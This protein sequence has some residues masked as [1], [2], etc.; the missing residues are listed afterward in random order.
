M[1]HTLATFQKHLAG[2]DLKP[3]YLIAGEEHLLVLEAADALRAHARAL[4]YNERE[5]LDAETHF[6]WDALARAG[7]SMSLFASRRL[8]DMRLPTGKPG[9]EGSDAIVEYCENPPPDTVLMIVAN[10]WS[11]QQQAGAWVNAIERAGVVLP[12]WP[13]KA[14]EL[15][16]WIGQRMASR[17]LK[18]DRAAIAALADRVEGNSL[19]AAQE[20]D[21]L[22]LLHGSKP[23]DADTLEQ[24]V[25]DSARFDVFKLIDAALEGDTAR[26]IRV[27][28][29]LRAEGEQVPALM[30]WVLNQLQLIARL[31]SGPNLSSAF[32]NEHVWPA[33]ERVY[34]QALSRAD[35]KHWEKCLI[36][37]AR[38][39]RL[40]KGRGWGDP[41]R[42][43]ER[44]LAAVAMPR[45]KLLA[46]S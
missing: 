30:G 16:D 12:V 22:V 44:L 41:W 46:A 17:G 34:R 40:S 3:A 6:D 32:R 23:L 5:V 15:P 25:T 42:E 11:K 7:A 18:P 14:D 35:R 1:A 24:L 27:L 43:L 2:P 13:L 36:Q 20:I 8:I 33:R 31:A 9:K 21:K 4:D 19:A 45:A 29:G 39:D 37:A 28:Q 38:V 10:Q 26:T